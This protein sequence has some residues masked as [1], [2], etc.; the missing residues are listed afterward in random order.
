MILLILYIEKQCC[1]VLSVTIYRDLYRSNCI[2]LISFVFFS[3]PIV[4]LSI[5][6]PSNN[7][8]PLKRCHTFGAVTILVIGMSLKLQIWQ[9]CFQ[10]TFHSIRIFNTWNVSNVINKV[11]DLS[12]MFSGCTLLHQ[13]LH[14]H[15][16]YLYSS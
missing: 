4:S 11:R 7:K 10:V 15:Q 8:Y 1:G 16:H 3:Q 9:I 13:P 2:L 12:L 5:F 6:Q 14:I